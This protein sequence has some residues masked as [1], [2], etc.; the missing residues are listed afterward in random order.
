MLPLIYLNG[1]L[2]VLANY[3]Y[4]AEF[5]FYAI[6]FIGG[7]CGFAIGFVTTLQIKVTSPLTHNISGTGKACAQT[8]MATVIYSETKS[9]LWWTSN[10]V[11]IVGTFLYAKVKQLEMA[12][13]HHDSSNNHKV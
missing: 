4:I 8:L 10:L 3:Q 5:W 7:L 2:S 1:E 13:K 11:V 12:K 9:F 6:M